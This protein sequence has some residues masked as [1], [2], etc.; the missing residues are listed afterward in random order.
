[1]ARIGNSP[2]AYRQTWHLPCDDD[3]LTYAGLIALASELFE[4]E[5]DYRVL[6][7][8]FF[9]LGGL[10]N[11]RLREVRELLPRYGQDNIFVSDKF[12]RHFPD[13]EVMPY[14]EGVACIRDEQRA[15]SEGSE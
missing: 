8:W 2:E 4:R 5:L 12:K 14:A 7:R 10:F 1:M 6:G 11:Q 9:R 3:R 13:F 15:E